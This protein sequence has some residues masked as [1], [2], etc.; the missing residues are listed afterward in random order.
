M[1]AQTEHGERIAIL[2][3]LIVSEQEWRR[4]QAALLDRIEAGQRRLVYWI[5]GTGVGVASVLV[6]AAQLFLTG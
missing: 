1:A 6:G 4:E 5:I 3:T 2:E